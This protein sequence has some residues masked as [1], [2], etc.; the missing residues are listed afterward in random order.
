MREILVVEIR[1]GWVEEWKGGVLVGGGVRVESRGGGDE[2]EGVMGVWVV[3][4][5]GDERVDEEGGELVGE[6]GKIG[7]G[8]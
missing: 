1:G 3:D 6:V 4:V 2:V 5:E 7:D 8:M